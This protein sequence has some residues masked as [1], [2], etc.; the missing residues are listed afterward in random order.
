LAYVTAVPLKVT[1]YRL[2]VDTRIGNKTLP[3]ILDTGSNISVL[4]LAT[5]R[6]LDLRILP[7]T[8]SRFSSI[9]MHGMGGPREASIMEAPHVHLGDVSAPGMRFAVLD[10]PRDPAIGQD[11]D[12]LG[13]N[14]LSSF[15]IDID[16]LGHRL[17]LFQ[18]NDMCREPRVLMGGPFY[19]VPMFGDPRD[20]HT[21]VEVTIAGKVLTA[22]LDTGAPRSA[23][24]IG[25]AQ[26]VGLTDKILAADPHGKDWG[27]GSDALNAARHVSAPMSI[28]DLTIANMR[29]D[30]VDGHLLGTDM[31]LG[32]DFLTKVHTW[33]SNSTRTVV[34]QVP[35]TASPPV[36][37]L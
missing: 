31:V 7:T 1:P 15:D 14:P 16:M 34:F 17:V 37:G 26:L 32:M 6:S 27:I 29:V 2:I 36:P 10:G 24:T 28:G 12:L 20:L 5:A 22:M 19:K 21:I 25:A 23:M 30:V 18:G 13:M 9:Q 4:S 3:L 33:I 35:P 11:M 8:G